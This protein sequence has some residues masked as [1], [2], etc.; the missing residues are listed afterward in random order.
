MG[1][2]ARQ[3]RRA[4][5]KPPLP[6]GDAAAESLAAWADDPDLSPAE[7]LVR[8]SQIGANVDSEGQALVN[9]LQRAGRAEKAQR[10]LHQAVLDCREAGISWDRIG[11]RLGVNGETARRRYGS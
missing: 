9:L 5:P 11:M 6:G 7:R 4:V 10:E 2:T 8:R 3:A 1:K